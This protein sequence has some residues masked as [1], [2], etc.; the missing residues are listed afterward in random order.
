MRYTTG[1][2]I[3]CGADEELHHYETNQCPKH[4]IE[5]M[6]DGHKQEWDETTFY[7]SGLSKL[8]AAAPELLEA[9]ILLEKAIPD[10]GKWD[11]AAAMD[12]ARSV[13]KKATL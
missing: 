10:N 6:R 4:G 1:K 13:I 5:E 12:N 2:C 8:E 11:Y 3:Y 7:D 9:L